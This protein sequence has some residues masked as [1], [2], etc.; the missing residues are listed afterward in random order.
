MTVYLY[1]SLVL[2]YFLNIIF[3]PHISLVSY[4]GA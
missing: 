4:H 1:I 2:R 3:N